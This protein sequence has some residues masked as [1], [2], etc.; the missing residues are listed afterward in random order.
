MCNKKLIG[1][2]LEEAELFLNKTAI[3]IYACEY[4]VIMESYF[5]GIVKKRIHLSIKNGIIYDC[6]V[7]IDL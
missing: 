7:R 2:S 4:A 1:K 5:F 6:F 3:R